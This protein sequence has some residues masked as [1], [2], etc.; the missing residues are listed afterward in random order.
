M[1]RSKCNKPNRIESRKKILSKIL[2]SEKELNL[3]LFYCR[4]IMTDVIE[5][6]KSTS[7]INLCNKTSDS[8]LAGM[9]SFPFLATQGK[10]LNK[11]QI[12]TEVDQSVDMD[13]LISEEEVSVEE[14]S[15]AQLSSSVRL[16]L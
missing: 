10:T 3:S 8:D 12:D 14:N 2:S 7:E 9:S 11:L 13:F 16:V 1:N 6:N 5:Q 4:S 15:I